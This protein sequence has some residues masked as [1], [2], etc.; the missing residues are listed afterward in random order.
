VQWIFVAVCTVLVLAGVRFAIRFLALGVLALPVVLL[1]PI[2]PLWPLGEI[3]IAMCTQLI[4]A[5]GFLLFIFRLR[6]I[7]SLFPAALVVLILLDLLGDSSLLKS[8]LMSYSVMEGARYYGIGN[9]YGGAL[10]G[11]LLALACFHPARRG[12]VVAALL[13]SAILA[14]LPQYGANLGVMVGG[15]AAAAGFAAYAVHRGRKLIIGGAA[16]AIV[17]AIAVLLLFDYLRGAES[18]SHLGRALSGGIVSIAARK[19]SLN[20]YLVTHSPWSLALST[21][22]GAIWLIRRRFPNPEQGP[23]VAGLIAGAT[24]LFIFN[25]SG[26]VAAACCV[27]P[28][29]A[30]IVLTSI[31]S[32]RLSNIGG[33]GGHDSD[34][35]SAA[36]SA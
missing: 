7:Q 35:G 19:L 14:G 34:R 26:V 23:A 17:A 5:I 18:Q 1:V 9:E 8:G 30:A 28:V 20:L 10:I 24:A 12:F 3:F 36:A 2:D 22:A 21:A 13:V 32:H 16:V 4:L 15:L 6:W 25:D 27:L 11:A 33:E 31:G 29:W